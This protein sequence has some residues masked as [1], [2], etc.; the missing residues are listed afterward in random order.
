MTQT[1]TTSRRRDLSIGLGTVAFFAV[2]LL[3][4]IPYQIRVPA[5]ITVLALS[6]A[7][8]PTMVC[9]LGILIGLIIVY[10][11]LR[12]ISFDDDDPLA[13]TEEPREEWRSV[14]AVVM[15]FVY[16]GLVHVLGML[17]ASMLALLALA[18]L[19]GERRLRIL[20][21]VAV[22][23]PLGLYYFFTMI[24]HVPLPLGLF[25]HLA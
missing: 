7:F 19:F 21:P 20:L 16:L 14:A 9:I 17:V 15:M 22:L 10:R 25:Q 11:G 6:P 3:A 12:G 18:W 4:V 8:W 2:V 13:A 1:N 23:L 5:N 24:A